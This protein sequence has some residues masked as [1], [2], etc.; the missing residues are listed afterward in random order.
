MYSIRNSRERERESDLGDDGTCFVLDERT[1]PNIAGHGGITRILYQREF[2]LGDGRLGNVLSV[3]FVDPEGLVDKYLMFY[4][5]GNSVVSEVE[6]VVEPVDKSIKLEH[7]SIDKDN[8]AKAISN[9]FNGTRYDD[10]DVTV[11]EEKIR[12]VFDSRLEGL[13]EPSVEDYTAIDETLAFLEKWFE[14][15]A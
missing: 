8:S 1:V 14:A 6:K 9:I 15:P 7:T 5:D 2:E 12:S 3:H 11:I 13:A 4:A 10:E